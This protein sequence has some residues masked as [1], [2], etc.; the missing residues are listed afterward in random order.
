M[1]AA[2]L[3][4]GEAVSVVSAWVGE[5]GRLAQLVSELQ[6]VKRFRLRLDFERVDVKVGVGI[7]QLR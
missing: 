7:P 6:L 4:F 1:R 2:I 3:G 5:L